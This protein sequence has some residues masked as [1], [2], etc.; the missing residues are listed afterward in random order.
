[1][2]DWRLLL[3]SAKQ[4]PRHTV[5]AGL[6]ARRL[7]MPRRKSRKSRKPRPHRRTIVNAPDHKAVRVLQNRLAPGKKPMLDV[8]DYQLLRQVLNYHYP[9]TLKARLL[10]VPT[11][12]WG[13]GLLILIALLSGHSFFGYRLTRTATES[14]RAEYSRSLGRP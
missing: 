13:V 7:S 12:L 8:D 2:V 1:M 5:A 10:R 4:Q 3:H 9:K 6:D 14:A 11:L